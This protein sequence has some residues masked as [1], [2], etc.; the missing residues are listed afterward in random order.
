LRN[1]CRRDNG[2]PSARRQ[3]KLRVKQP[4]AQFVDYALLQGG[5][6]WI[7][8]NGR[9]VQEECGDAYEY[10]LAGTETS[11]RRTCP[12]FGPRPLARFVSKRSLA[13][14]K[15]L[16]SQTWPNRDRSL[17]AYGSVNHRLQN[18]YAA[19][20]LR[21]AR[22]FSHIQANNAADLLPVP[23]YAFLLGWWFNS[24]LKA[25]QSFMTSR[26]E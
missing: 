13:T 7:A 24:M 5:R 10:P 18:H 25:G 16:S 17:P 23:Y 20:F 22:H 21:A 4:Q 12:V 14:I 6:W 1:E 19:K 26:L 8:I 3:S 2:N 15:V 11:M 9:S